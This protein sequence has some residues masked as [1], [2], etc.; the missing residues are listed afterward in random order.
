MNIDDVYRLAHEH[1]DHDSHT[2]DCPFCEEQES[3]YRT[4]EWFE[5]V[6]LVTRVGEFLKTKGFQEAGA[7]VVSEAFNLVGAG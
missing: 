7:L 3:F 1:I 4:V 6:Q 5:K 2:A